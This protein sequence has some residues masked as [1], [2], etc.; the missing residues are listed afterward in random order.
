MIIALILIAA[1]GAYILFYNRLIKLSN[2]AKERWGGVDVQ[3]KHRHDLIP[4]LVKAAEKYSQSKNQVFIDLS[5]RRNTARMATTIKEKQNCEKKLNESLKQFFAI[6]ET[7][8]EL[9]TDEQY[10]KLSADMN[11]VEESLQNAKNQYN[12]TVKEYNNALHT[13]PS[14]WVGSAMQLKDK[15]FFQVSDAERGNVEA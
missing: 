7:Y 8:P 9:K 15:N 2:V 1:I 4:Q 12:E 3:L 10:L 14:C 11:E 5:D 6:I 13:I